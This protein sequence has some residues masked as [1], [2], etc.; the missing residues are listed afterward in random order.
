M[1]N[2]LEA[3]ANGI[4]SYAPDNQG[5][6]YDLGTVAT[7][8]C[9]D[10][11]ILIGSS[12]RVCEDDGDILG[13]FAGIAPSCERVAIEIMFVEPEYTAFEDDMTVVVMVITDRPVETPL[14]FYVIGGNLIMHTHSG[15]YNYKSYNYIFNCCVRIHSVISIIMCC[16]VQ[17]KWNNKLL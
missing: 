15:L 8:S 6:E 10:G 16:I 3:I 11:F 12:N 17:C 9:D 2:E 1:C 5:P 14:S 7:Y 13:T 4:I